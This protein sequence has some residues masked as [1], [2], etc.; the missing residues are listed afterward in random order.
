MTVTVPSKPINN[1]TIGL[2][3]VSVRK[4]ASEESQGFLER[5]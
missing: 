4:V 3:R 1:I 5:L 2:W